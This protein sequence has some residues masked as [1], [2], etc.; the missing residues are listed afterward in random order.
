MQRRVPDL[1]KL[2]AMVGFRP[3]TPL[4]EIIQDVIAAHRGAVEAAAS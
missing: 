3:R 4:D 1:R 2:E